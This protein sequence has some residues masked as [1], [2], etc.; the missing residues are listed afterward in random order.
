MDKFAVVLAAGQGTRMKSDLYKV[1]HPVCGKA[2]VQHVIDAV[3]AIDIT[4]VVTVVG[5][6]ADSVKSV[7]GTKSNFV[8]QDAQLGTA[9]AVMKAEPLLS[10]KPGTTV[11]LCGDTPLIKVSTLENLLAVHMSNNASATVLTAIAPDPTGYGR[12]IRDTD[13]HVTKIVEHKDCDEG[14]LRVREFN[15]GI[16]CFDNQL[17]FETLKKVGNQNTQNEFYLTDVIEILQQ[18]NKTVTAFCTPDFDETLGVNDRVQLAQ[19]ERIMQCRIN[20]Q[21]MRNGV[22]I[23]DP[24][25]TYIHANVV[26]GRDSLIRPGS[27]ITGTTAIGENCIIGPNS[28]IHNCQI[29]NSVTIRQST[30]FDSTIAHEAQVGPFAHIRPTSELGRGVKI[31]N[32]VEVK[33]ATIDTNSKVSHLSYIGDAKIGRDVNIG[34]GTITVNYDGK[35]KFQT[36]IEDGSFVGCN[37]NLIAPVVI[38]KNAIIAAGST[39]TSDVP[40]DSLSIA[41][42][43]Q[44]DKLGYAKKRK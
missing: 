9:H 42:A 34:C 15:T 20:E 18:E 13:G 22:T 35:S 38:G 21:H 31:G 17:L 33:K 7:L 5:H 28:E 11:V 32:F 27:V 26:I 25:A 4:Q 10:G 23:T 40:A 29:G 24:A 43:R 14:Q 6:G 19:A 41:R 36:T 30:T 8:F 39:I 12:I 44:V 37:A 2:M 3:S 16:F 1:L